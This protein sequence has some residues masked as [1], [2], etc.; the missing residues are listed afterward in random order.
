M[1]ER[2]REREKDRK[3]ER[4]KERKRER[5]KERKREREK[6]RK[7]EGEKERKKH[8]TQFNENRHRPMR[9]TLFFRD[10]SFSDQDVPKRMLNN[11]FSKTGVF[12]GKSGT[13]KKSPVRPP[14]LT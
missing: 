9:I 8:M 10:P 11:F 12:G 14:I 13:W 7:T 5:Q 1:Q 6:D 4:E 2:K 3:R